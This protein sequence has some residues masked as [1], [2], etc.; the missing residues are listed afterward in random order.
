MDLCY[1][2][3]EEIPEWQRPRRATGNRGNESSMWRWFHIAGK[4]HTGHGV[5]L[6]LCG[7]GLGLG[8]GL[9]G[10][11]FLCAG[12]YVALLTEHEWSGPQHPAHG[13]IT[14][15]GILFMTWWAQGVMNGWLLV[16]LSR[17]CCHKVSWA[18][19]RLVACQGVRRKPFMLPPV[20]GN[21]WPCLSRVNFSHFFTLRLCCRDLRILVCL[22]TGYNIL[23]W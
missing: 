13:G 10:C 7:V 5:A 12:K 3:P 16:F 22:L 8:V 23:N 20:G 2:S 15:P 17:M 19:V 14:F 11:R 18:I 4:C 21:F 1:A 6:A 9:A